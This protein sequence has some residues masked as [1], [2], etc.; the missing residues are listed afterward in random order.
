MYAYI[1][2][3]NMSSRFH[4]NTEANNRWR[5]VFYL[6]IV[7]SRS[8]I[9]DNDCYKNYSLRLINVIL[10][11]LFLDWWPSSVGYQETF[12]SNIPSKCFRIL[13]WSLK[14]IY[15]RVIYT[16]TPMIWNIEAIYTKW[17]D[18][19]SELLNDTYLLHIDHIRIN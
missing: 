2:L 14:H 13:R 10:R 5:T 9:D 7:N 17:F 8:W 15:C 18:M 1:G 12:A 4:I 3:K 6:L 11:R 16:T 19:Y